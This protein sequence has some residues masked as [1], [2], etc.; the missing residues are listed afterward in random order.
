MASTGKNDAPCTRYFVTGFNLKS[1]DVDSMESK[2]PQYSINYTAIS[3]FEEKTAVNIYLNFKTKVRKTRVEDL[4]NESKVKG[5]RIDNFEN[6]GGL[7]ASVAVKS[8][9]EKQDKA[10]YY[11]REWGDQP[12]DIYR[13]LN[14]KTKTSSD[15]GTEEEE[16]D[17]KTFRALSQSLEECESRMGSVQECMEGVNEKLEGFNENLSE[18]NANLKRELQSKESVIAKLSKE[19]EERN[20]ELSERNKEL[21]DRK[22]SQRITFEN[23]DR[24]ESECMRLRQENNRLYAEMSANNHLSVIREELTNL[25]DLQDRRFRAM[26]LQNNT[27]FR[28]LCE[29]LGMRNQDPESMDI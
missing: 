16:I 25:R 6:D 21:S 5:F 28:V 19:L 9:L 4:L 22:T 7:G 29:A 20:K 24:A 14:A 10:G 3:L 23:L 2:F 8:I 1:D 26:T 12:S 18:L 11:V 27:R 15:T 17:D 13:R